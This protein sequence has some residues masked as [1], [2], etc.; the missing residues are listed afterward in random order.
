MWGQYDCLYGDDEK[1][2]ERLVC[3]G[4]FKCRGENRCVGPEEVC[5]RHLNCIHSFDDEL[6]CRP[7]SKDCECEGYIMIYCKKVVST[8]G[9][10]PSRILYMKGLVVNVLLKLFIVHYIYKLNLIYL[11]LSSC[12]LS[13]IID[14]KAYYMTPRLLFANFSKNELQNTMI[15]GGR[16]FY[17]VL[18]LDISENYFTN[19]KF[20]NE[21]FQYII[22]MLLNGNPLKKIVSGQSWPNLKLLEFKYVQFEPYIVIDLPKECEIAVSHSA[23]CCVLVRHSMCRSDTD[24]AIACFGLLVEVSHEIYLYIVIVVCSLLI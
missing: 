21:I 13:D 6:M 14:N 10:V 4:F 11:D 18:V 1:Y 19:L 24:R 16:F 20:Q 23:I 5:D 17:N 7:C 9:S 15:F 8:W 3:P 2:C 22:V 12:S